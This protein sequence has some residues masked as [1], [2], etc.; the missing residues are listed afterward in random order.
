[1]RRYFGS[2]SLHSACFVYIPHAYLWQQSLLMQGGFQ[3]EGMQGFWSAWYITSGAFV[4][5]AWYSITFQQTSVTSA[6]QTL[7]K[8]VDQKHQAPTDVTLY[9][10]TK[11]TC[12]KYSKLFQSML[13]QLPTMTFLHSID[14]H[15]PCVSRSTL[16]KMHHDISWLDSRITR[17]DVWITRPND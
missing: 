17:C 3:L 10:Y 15:V 4:F 12:S 2:R 14:L 7:T 6:K 1:M 11:H 5:W 13:S 9:Y 8:K 16:D